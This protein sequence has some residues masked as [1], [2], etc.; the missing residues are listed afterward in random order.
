MFMRYSLLLLVLLSMTNQS[1]CAQSL[2]LQ[3]D[4]SRSRS[5]QAQKQISEP[6]TQNGVTTDQ[7]TRAVEVW[8]AGY[9]APGGLTGA[10]P[11]R[12]TSVQSNHQG[13]RN[14]PVYSK[15]NQVT[16]VFTDQ[17]RVYIRQLEQGA[18]ALEQMQTNKRS[19][20][21]RNNPLGRASSSWE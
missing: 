10:G 9:S 8:K 12:L 13:T 18:A 11:Y 1:V 7:L 6:W 4:K 5:V 15:Q 20:S 14:T 17:L 2:T 19:L 16:P 21:Q 3:T